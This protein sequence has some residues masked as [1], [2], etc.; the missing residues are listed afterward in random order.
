MQR[1]SVYIRDNSVNLYREETSKN[2]LLIIYFPLETRTTLQIIYNMSQPKCKIQLIIILVKHIR[3][4]FKKV[5]EYGLF[6]II[7]G[8]KLPFLNDTFSSYLLPLFVTLLCFVSLS[9]YLFV[10]VCI[11]VCVY[12][13]LFELFFCSFAT[14]TKNVQEGFVARSTF[15]KGRRKVIPFIEIMAILLSFP[16]IHT[17]IDKLGR[18]F[19]IPVIFTLVEEFHPGYSAVANSPCAVANT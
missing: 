4:F 12:Y 19:T 1:L 18:F 8:E 7:Q 14:H 10:Y 9:L 16:D 15:V 13:G 17:Y 2:I 3:D 6:L 5:G 11:H